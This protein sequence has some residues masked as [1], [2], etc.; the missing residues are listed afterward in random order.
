ML[1]SSFLNECCSYTVS[2][3]WLLVVCMLVCVVEYVC[4]VDEPSYDPIEKEVLSD[5]LEV[6]LK[7]FKCSAADILWNYFR[8]LVRTLSTRLPPPGTM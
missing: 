4:S 2:A 8:F 6:W 1:L 5:E 3:V 7:G